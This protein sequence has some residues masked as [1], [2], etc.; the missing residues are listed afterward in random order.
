VELAEAPEE[1]L[2]GAGRGG[3]VLRRGRVADERREV[4][5][6]RPRDVRVARQNGH[7]VVE[8]RDD[9]VGGADPAHGTGLR[10]LAD[11][12]TIVDGRSRSSAPPGEGTTVRAQIPCA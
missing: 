12:L 6:G 7:A 5:A 1:R 3:R 2:P 10:G 11:R 9:G 8:V 4:R